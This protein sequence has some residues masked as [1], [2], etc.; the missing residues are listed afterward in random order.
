GGGGYSSPVDLWDVLGNHCSRAR[1][2]CGVFDSGRQ[3]VIEGRKL[4]L[5]ADTH[6]LLILFQQTI[7]E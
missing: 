4:A 6:L 3:G 5:E 1:L 7:D 2:S